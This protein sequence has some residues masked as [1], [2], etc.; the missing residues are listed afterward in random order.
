MSLNSIEQ[1]DGLC[2]Q[3]EIRKD[4]TRGTEEQRKETETERTERG[5]YEQA[6]NQERQRELEHER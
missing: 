3:R 6:D 5:R 4:K 2:L 1:R